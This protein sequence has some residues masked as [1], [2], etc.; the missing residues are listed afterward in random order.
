VKT[1]HTG[2]ANSLLDQHKN[3]VFHAMNTITP[4][5]GGSDVRGLFRYNEN[6]INN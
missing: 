1:I 6:N 5:V 3:I 4:M 2:I